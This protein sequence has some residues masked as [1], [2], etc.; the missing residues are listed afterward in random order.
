L[1]LKTLFSFIY[2][3]DTVVQLLHDNKTHTS[4][5]LLNRG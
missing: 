1:Y 4:F 2:V 3:T 5:D